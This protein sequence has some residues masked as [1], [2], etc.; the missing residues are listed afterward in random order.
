MHSALSVGRAQRLR[1]LDGWRA[2]SVIL[3]IMHH[4]GTWQYPDLLAHHSILSHLAFWVGPLGVKTFFT[5]SGF[6]ICRLLI[7]EE[8]KHGSVSLKGFYY[9]RIFRILPPLY[10]YLASL[11]LLVAAGLVYERGRAVVYSALF[12]GDS[13]I[14][15]TTW[16]AGHTWSLA[17]EE[18]FYLIFPTAWVLTPPRWRRHAFFGAFLVFIFW[19]LIPLWRDGRVQG[20]ACISIG[21]LMALHEQRV[22]LVVARVPAFLVAL[23]ALVLL[24]HPT[25]Q[26][27]LKE[28]LYEGVLVPPAI[29][30]V[31]VFS[32]ERA[33][34]LRKIL[35]SAPM[36]AIG[37]MSYGIYLWQQLFTGPKAAYH[38]AGRI[39]PLLLPALLIVV[40][41]SYFFLEKPAMRYGKS[42][43]LRTPESVLADGVAAD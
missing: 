11:S 42:L 32:L 27:G 8:W 36:Q 10:V 33:P 22:R 31:L 1:E 25:A 20:A 12:M 5:I 19:S 35:C 39:I 43:S 24:A 28:A 40:P 17:V 38:G 4:L 9:R 30:L 18:Q 15:A 7:Q 14:V 23:T 13:L 29:A 6:V 2:V 41:L 26:G 16:F 3:V 34:W 37:L 21:V